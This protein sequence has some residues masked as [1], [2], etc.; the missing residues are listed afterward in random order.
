LYIDNNLISNE[1]AR[2]IAKLI[3]VNQ[4]LTHLYIEGNTIEDEGADFI[5]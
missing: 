1:G 5:A 2:F 4:G 3:A